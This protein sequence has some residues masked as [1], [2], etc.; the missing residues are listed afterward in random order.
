MV[1]NVIDEDVFPGHRSKPTAWD[2][3]TTATT[4]PIGTN[5]T[6]VL[7]SLGGMATVASLQQTSS[8]VQCSKPTVWDGDV[9]VIR[10]MFIDRCLWVL[11]SLGGMVT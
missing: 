2:G 5:H 10:R 9:C 6:H 3:D 4:S 8:L 11:S 7:S 1:T